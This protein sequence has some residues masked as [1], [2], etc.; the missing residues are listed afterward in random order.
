MKKILTLFLGLA[1][2]AFSISTQA[3]ESR[4]RIAG[5]TAMS[6]YVSYLIAL[7][8]Q[9]LDTLISKTEAARNFVGFYKDL[10]CPMP[11]LYQAMECFSREEDKTRDKKIS[12]VAQ[13]CLKESG[14]TTN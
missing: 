14:V 10:G 1:I 7:G 12:D 9:D 6:G 2:S 13:Q 4:C 5:E 3:S 11:P 8:K